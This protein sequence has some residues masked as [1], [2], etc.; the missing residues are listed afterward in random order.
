MQGLSSQQTTIHSRLPFVIIFLIVMAGYLVIN[1]ANFQFFPRSV[2]QEMERRGSAITSSTRRIPAERGLIYDRD[3]EPLAFN[4]LQYRVGVSPSLVADALG[5]SRQLALILDID[6]FEIHRRATSENLWEFVAGPISADQ[7]QAIAALDEISVDLERIPKRF[8]PQGP[9]AGHVIGFVVDEQLKGAMGVE[10]A[11]NDTLAGRV[12][13]LSISNV[14]IDL[15]EDVPTDQRGQD[16]LLTLDRDVQF[17]VESE[18]ER[19][20]L[21]SGAFRGSVIVMDPRNGDILAMA[22]DPTLDPNTF[23]E[24]EDPNLLLNPSINEDFEPGS[25]VQALTV[26]AGLETGA[27]TPYWTYND[28]G[29]LD[30][31]GYKIWNR[32]FQT[33]G[34]IDVSQILVRSVNVGAATIA[35]E[36]GM[37]NFYSMMRAFG[38]GQITGVDLFAEESGELKVPGDSNW[39]ESYLGLNS[40]GQRMKATPLQMITAF[41]AI[42]NNGIMRQPRIVRQAITEDGVQ[43]AQAITIRRVISEETASI[44]NDLLVQSATE[45]A[46]EAQLPGYTIA[47]K[48]GTARIATALDYEVG[49]NSSIVTFIGFLPADDPQVVVMVKLDRPDDYYGYEVAAPVFRRLADRLV[50]LL[51]IPVDEVRHNLARSTR[52]ISSVG[53]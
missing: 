11:Y 7:G 32:R 33:H 10:G 5:L 16:I 12:L 44:V 34:T 53:S 23:L 14:P 46:P 3:G 36:M 4:A 42:A 29:N 6:E 40:Y 15:P 9:L 13:D 48:A 22:N 26:A 31:G 24:V 25:I 39:S 43:N 8:Y 52:N 1:L 30:V 20:V 47:G 50:I 45:G 21:E 19:A 41:A 17:W 37:D 51:E 28:E 27:I 18:L 49:R 38:L 2:R 35:L